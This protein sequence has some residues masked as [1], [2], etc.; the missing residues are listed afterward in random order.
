MLRESE[1]QVANKA[2]VAKRGIAT[3]VCAACVSEKFA[4]KIQLFAGTRRDV[5]E[6][7]KFIEL[8][9]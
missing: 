1:K 7:R 4:L 6:G 8:I 5:P 2:L 9:L 3:K